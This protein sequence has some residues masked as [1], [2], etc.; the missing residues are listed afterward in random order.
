MWKRWVFW[1]I[2]LS[3]TAAAVWYLQQTV[4]LGAAWE[5]GKSLTPAMMAAAFALLVVH[6]VIC[7]ARW[8]LVVRAIGGSLPLSRAC[9]LACIGNFFGQVLPSGVGGD[10]VRVWQTHTAGLP[11]SVS[12]NS[13]ALDRVVTVF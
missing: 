2:K 13:V 9:V 6:I 4:D 12:F 8:A 10:A 1:L 3:F 5:V 11:L 7:A